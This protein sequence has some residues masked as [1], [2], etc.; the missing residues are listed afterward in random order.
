MGFAV[1]VARVPV[2]V[3]AFQGVSRVDE[4]TTVLVAWEQKEKEKAKDD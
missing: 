2:A 4:R 1:E 3:A